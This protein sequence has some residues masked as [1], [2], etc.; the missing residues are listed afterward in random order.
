MILNTGGFQ[1]NNKYDKKNLKIIQKLSPV[2][3][4]FLENELK[5][6]GETIEL[7]A[8]ENFCSEAIKAAC[9][10]A[11]TNKY[12]EGYPTHRYSGREMRYYGGCE[13]VDNLE[14]YCC[15]MWREV[16]KTDYH[17][18]VQP[19]S[20]SQ[21]NFAAYM[22]ILNPH[23]K[24]LSMS[25]D[26]GAHLTHGASVNFSGK[27]YNMSFYNTDKDGR[28]DYKNIYDHIISDQ[29]KLV[30]AGASAY[31]REID[32]KQIKQM[33]IKATIV[34][35]EQINKEYHIPYFMVDMA[36]IAGLI[37][38]GVHQSPFGVADIITTTTHKTLRGPRGGL[39]FCKKELAKSVDGAVFPGSQGGPLEHIIA[40]KA[41]C[42][43]EACTKEY[44]DYIRRVV[45]N[46][47]VMAEEFKKLGYKIVTNGT[48]NHLFLIDLRHNHPAIT[49]LQ[50]QEACD[51]NNITLNKNC[52][53]NESRSP[54]ETSG[55]RI[56]TAAMTT[57]GYTAIDFIEVT[58]KID[59]I[60][61]ELDGKK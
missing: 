7:I 45:L 4:S 31:S 5:R 36:H 60:I 12:A 18:N 21:A 51:K 27:L 30:L 48:D 40:G 9:G 14:E 29:P 56:G 32:F 33:I 2:V 16:F 19:H 20:G 42:A 55:I 28:I 61:C 44:K 46:C 1:M 17:V 59:K 22:S 3:G 11:F 38:A 34:I 24:I 54:K 57:K 41:I 43:E 8:S 10:S 50:V 6:Q 23:D 52:V 47:K 37:A 53:P 58:H 26:N 15:N 39:I 25:L 49:G 35:K 13:N